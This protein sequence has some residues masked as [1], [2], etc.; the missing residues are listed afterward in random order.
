MQNFPY[1]LIL[2][3]FYYS[4]ITGMYVVK[5]QCCFSTRMHVKDTWK[6]FF[7][8][9]KQCTNLI[10]REVKLRAVWHRFPPIFFQLNPQQ[11][12]S[13]ET[14]CYK[15]SSQSIHS[16][17]SPRLG[18]CWPWIWGIALFISVEGLFCFFSYCWLIKKTGHCFVY[19]RSTGTSTIPVLVV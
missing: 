15:K 8:T 7:N 9:I 4:L 3:V 14:S 16:M 10:I 19:K 2:T 12:I 17:S 1:Y 5:V 6:L 13:P 11:P 18:H